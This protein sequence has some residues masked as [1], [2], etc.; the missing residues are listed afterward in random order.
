MGNGTAIKISSKDFFLFS[1]LSPPEGYSRARQYST[2][3]SSVF[4]DL[5]AEHARVIMQDAF[6][7]PPSSAAAPAPALPAT[8]ASPPPA[9]GPSLS[10]FLKPSSAAVARSA[11]EITAKAE[12]AR[13]A[14]RG[15]VVHDALAV[16]TTSLKRAARGA[17]KSVD[18]RVRSPRSGGA[19]IDI[20]NKGL[21]LRQRVQR[22]KQSDATNLADVV[23]DTHVLNGVASRRFQRF[24]PVGQNVTGLAVSS[25]GG[26]LAIAT[27]HRVST[28]H[29][30]ESG[31]VVRSLKSQGN[32]L[33][34]AFS[35]DSAHIATGAK[36]GYISVFNASTGAPLCEMHSEHGNIR[37]V[38]FHPL[39][40]SHLACACDD[41]T[42]IVVDWRK[43]KELR[44]SMLHDGIVRCL[45]FSHN[46]KFV[47]TGSRD[48]TSKISSIE[49][50][51]VKMIFE[52]HSAEVYDV[53]F[54]HDGCFL[55]TC[56]ADHTCVIFDVQ[57]GSVV[58]TLI[59]H[60][61][62]IYSIAF[63]PDDQYI[64]S[65]S[66]DRTAILWH[67]S[68][69]TL[70]RR[71][72]CHTE[73]VRTVAFSSDQ[74]R[75]FT[76]AWDKCAVIHDVRAPSAVHTFVNHKGMPV[77][78]VAFSPDASLIGSGSDDHTARLADMR[79]GEIV[80]VVEQHTAS[81]RAVSF[82]LN[83]RLFA[84]GSLDCTVVLTDLAS[85][86]CLRTMSFGQR[87][88]SVQFTPDSKGVAAAIADGCVAIKYVW[89]DSL[90]MT[91]HGHSAAV[92]CIDFTRDGKRIATGSDDY[93]CLVHAMST[94]K[95]IVTLS[96]HTAKISSVAFTP[97]AKALATASSDCTAH[98][99]NTETWSVLHTVTHEGYVTAVGFSPCSRYLAT[100]S[101]DAT[102]AIHN[103]KSGERMHIV[104]SHAKSVTGVAFSSGEGA[105]VM[106]AT[107]S[108]DGSTI[109][110][111]LLP[112]TE[113]PNAKDAIMMLKHLDEKEVAGILS[114][115]PEFLYDNFSSSDGLCALQRLALRGKGLA[116]IRVAEAELP[117]PRS[118]KASK[119]LACVVEEEW[120]GDKL[121][122]LL[123]QYC[124]DDSIL[125]F[126]V[127]TDDGYTPVG[128]AALTNNVRFVESVM[129]S[130]L[131][132]D[133]HELPTDTLRVM[134]TGVDIIVLLERFP[135]LAMQYLD[136]PWLM[137]QARNEVGAGCELFGFGPGDDDVP[138]AWD[139]IWLARMLIR[140][141]LSFCRGSS[142]LHY[143]VADQTAPWALWRKNRARL[144]DKSALRVPTESVFIGIVGLLENSIDILRVATSA[145]D[146]FL[147]LF[148]KET[149]MAIID[150]KWETFGRKRFT[151]RAI[152]FAFYFTIVNIIAIALALER[153]S[154]PEMWASLTVRGFGVLALE[155]IAFT[156]SIVYLGLEFH[157][158]VV[159]KCDYVRDVFNWIDV[160]TSFIVIA[161]VLAHYFAADITT[162]AVLESIMAV[163]IWLRSLN[164][165]RAHSQLGFFVR[166]LL[167]SIWDAKL[168]AII[169]LLLGVLFAVAVF[170]LANAVEDTGPFASLVSGSYLAFQYMLGRVS[171]EDLEDVG[172]P[173]F[174]ALLL[175]TYML[176]SNVIMLN[177]VIAIIGDT[178][179]RAVRHQNQVARRE[180]A[181][182]IVEIEELDRSCGSCCTHPSTSIGPH[183]S[184]ETAPWC[185]ALERF[186]CCGGPVE[187]DDPSESGDKTEQWLH[188][189]RPQASGAAVDWR[190]SLRTAVMNS[191]D[192]FKMRMATVQKHMREEQVRARERE[193]D[194][195]KAMARLVWKL[196]TLS[197]MVRE[198]AKG[199][200][201]M[202]RRLSFRTTVKL[203]QQ[204][205][206]VASWNI[207]AWC[208][209]LSTPPPRGG[210]SLVSSHLPPPQL[211]H[212][213]GEQ[214]PIRVLDDG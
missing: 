29:D 129:R 119:E 24:V 23:R 53:C 45:A 39:E 173:A 33:C 72:V 89:D 165:V 64:L 52:A 164:F 35:L 158:M 82:S 90:I 68:A 161:V 131:L 105:P 69:G 201:T 3:M 8:I 200:S 153:Q 114:S 121:S 86:T 110:H 205:L 38:R 71:I 61:G 25:E 58:R 141:V 178:F 156:I 49:T 111:D 139:M 182:L 34:I 48:R 92:N 2:A 44:V 198:S 106:L 57:T 196:D 146:R 147:A 197:V 206:F 184:I 214:Q 133:Q 43:G 104:V 132:L 97:D 47:A 122:T 176:I 162:R 149:I 179:N 210:C 186:C 193:E 142:P 134:L 17:R 157:E 168:F 75:M 172:A 7:P 85:L 101:R 144:E 22:V 26:M 199:R 77:T 19:S 130:K 98:I 4:D 66:M 41:G 12:S 30:T 191:H 51:E 31:K 127:Q 56:S 14:R 79:T 96:T 20:G 128:L 187:E 152:L 166:L 73:S 5:S 170:P 70:V 138:E 62:Y 103:V 211:S 194:M 93:T 65:G 167:D 87:I 123:E 88:Y 28:I 83:G 202:T 94:R 135:D 126:P 21:E 208:C 32:T 169:L 113:M 112:L 91:T 60:T 42:V 13:S 195:H 115:Y 181:D 11:K 50:G 189:L 18:L 143:M 183:T 16:K 148:E 40:E 171:G 136:Q 37:R 203:A 180:R 188:I 207:G 84:S 155:V 185:Y 78:C 95:L 74:T 212:S 154:A 76:G 9:A 27:H 15:S 6:T 59:G 177:M 159:F 204:E 124:K 63:S 108:W 107:C 55:A 54:S 174:A 1:C 190:N 163:L 99:Y 46:G 137:V 192:D 100:C 109:I 150:F 209:P 10:S 102:A 117:V 145:E 118:L 140:P 160:S 213:V 36:D 175:C 67:W 151:M 116:S 80:Y 81:V 120:D 125:Y